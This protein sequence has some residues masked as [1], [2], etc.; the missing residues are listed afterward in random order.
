VRPCGSLLGNHII[1]DGAIKGM[2]FIGLEHRS[3]VF[4]TLVVGFLP[5]GLRI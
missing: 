2:D 5:C 3:L 4:H 1:N